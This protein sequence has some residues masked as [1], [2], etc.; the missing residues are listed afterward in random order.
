MWPMWFDEM[1]CK[2]YKRWGGDCA[3]LTGDADAR[4]Q[5]VDKTYRQEGA[6]VFESVAAKNR[7]LEDLA[8]LEV[9]MKADGSTLSTASVVMLQTMIIQLFAELK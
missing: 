1:M 6:P 9:G 2:L 4:A 7:F 3:D 5:T 8:E